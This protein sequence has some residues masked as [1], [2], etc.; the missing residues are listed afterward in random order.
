M[1]ARAITSSLA[2]LLVLSTPV[3]TRAGES[4]S[5]LVFTRAEGFVHAS[6]GDG[7]SMI[8]ALG[9][10][11][12]W[13]VDVTGETTLFTTSGLAG[14]D[15]VV[16]LSTTG[17]VL[18]AAEQSAF[19]GFVQAGGGYVG[20]H[21]AADCEYDW[22][23]YGQLLGNGAWFRSHPAI[24]D[25]T[26]E[27]ERP[28]HPT[29][30]TWPQQVTFNDEWYNFRANPRLVAEVVQTL[31]EQSYNP[32]TGAMGD[33]HPIAWMHAF[34][35]GRAFYTGLGH[36]TETYQ[37]PRFQAQI[38]GAIQWASGVLRFA[39]GFESGDTS[40]WTASTP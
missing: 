25:A 40:F 35:G 3:P 13:T 16:W 24:Q 2:L 32:G 15:V 37:D 29:A 33:D 34:D 22:P 31:D 10:A 26:L 28:G 12:G 14:Y 36:R 5:V 11:E 6:I 19:E 4:L 18:D 17:D 38:R 39:D 1:R 23:W 21:A 30:G 9:Q 20:I 8:T 27:L 7:V